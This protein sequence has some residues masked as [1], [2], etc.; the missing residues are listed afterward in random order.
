MDDE[1]ARVIHKIQKKER[2]IEKALQKMEANHTSNSTDEGVFWYN[3]P[4]ENWISFDK[5]FGKFMK[6]RK[7]FIHTPFGQGLKT[8][9]EAL[10]VTPQFKTLQ[11]DWKDY[12]QDP[13][14][15]K[16]QTAW[17]AY[18]D[19]ILKNITYTDEPEPFMDGPAIKQA[20]KF[21]KFVDDAFKG[22]LQR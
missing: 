22:K 13:G 20:K 19:A 2:K 5:K 21:V 17:A 4:N 3:I 1:T 8:R 7:Q 14:F 6:Y 9:L 11:Q 12:T 18:N 10:K 15:K 16:L